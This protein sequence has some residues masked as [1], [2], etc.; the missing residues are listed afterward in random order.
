MKTLK[1]EITR[2]TT[3]VEYDIKTKNNIIVI[4]KTF[5]MNEIEGNEEHYKIIHNNKF[6]NTLS[7]TEKDKLD[8]YIM[9]LTF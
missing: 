4:E 7:N 6:Y 1:N 8:D 2:Q 3:V 5:S 9:D